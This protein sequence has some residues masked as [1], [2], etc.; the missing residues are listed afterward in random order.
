MRLSA[1]FGQENA[2]ITF[3]NRR[4]TLCKYEAKYIALRTLE[5]DEHPSGS[6]DVYSPASWWWWNGNG[7]GGGIYVFIPASYC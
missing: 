6:I 1:H 5:N 2:L 7:R 4:V 3:P